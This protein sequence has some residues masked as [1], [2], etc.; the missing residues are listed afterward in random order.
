MVKAI[1][2]SLVGAAG[3]T[4]KR[5]DKAIPENSWGKWIFSNLRAFLRKLFRM[6]LYPKGN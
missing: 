3:T 6:V 1:P 5:I 4:L 2:D